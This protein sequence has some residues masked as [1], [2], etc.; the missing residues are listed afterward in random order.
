MN[1]IRL[2]IIGVGNMGSGHARNVLAGKCPDFELVAVAD[3]N[4]ERFA[5]CRET[6]PEVQAFFASAA[7]MLDSGLIDAC[8]V[9]VPHYDHANLAI[10]CMKHGIHVMVEK[11]ADVYTLQARKMNEE[12]DRHPEVVFGM[13]FNQRT[14]CLYR[15][16]R[17]LVQSGEYGAIRRTNWIITDWY[18][19]QAYYDSGDWRATWSGEGGGVLLNQ[20]PHQLDLW[21]WICGMPKKVYAHMHFGL[22]HDIEVED[23]V[24]AYVEY[25]NGATGV[26]VTTTGDA[27]GTNRFEIQMDRARLIAENGKLSLLEFDETEQ[28]FSAHNTTPFATV[29]CHEVPV[30]LDGSNEQHI[31]VLNAWA[32]AILRGGKM[33]ADGREGINGLTLSNAMHLSA[34][35]G[36]EI[37]LPL[38]EMMYRDEL[39]KRVASSRRKTGSKTVFADTSDTYGGAH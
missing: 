23:D 9:A 37:E 31:G 27:H 11:P 4:P 38:D 36:K 33:V 16:M 25:E 22:W 17:E 39:M 24:T 21:Q 30:E 34:F 19:P 20:C 8:I 18:R 29:G 35:C 10:E 13:M 26:F 32:D 7:E 2:G 12:A 14:N 15:K 6:F 28:A 3:H 1:K 5:W